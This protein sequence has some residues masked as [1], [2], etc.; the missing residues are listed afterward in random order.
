[1][2]TLTLIFALIFAS[3]LGCS[4]ASVAERQVLDSAQGSDPVRIDK[5]LVTPS[6]D[7]HREFIVAIQ[8][9]V[10]SVHLK[11]FR[12]T[13]PQVIQALISAKDRG[14]D[15]K[16]LLD[17]KSLKVARFNKTLNELERAG[18]LVRASSMGFSLTHEKSMVI[19]GQQAFVTGMNLTRN[20]KETRDFGIITRNQGITN[21]IE[22]VFAADWENALTGKAETPPLRDPN[23]IW[24][25]LNSR[26]KL[27]ALINS[28]RSQIRVQVENLGDPEIQRA[29]SEAA[30]RGCDVK[31]LVPMCDRDPKPLRNYP[32]VK[33]LL[34]E[35][36]RVQVMPFPAS[37]RRPYIHAK[38]ILIDK[39][40]IYLGSINFSKNS[41]MRARELGIVFEDPQNFQV[42]AQEFEKDWDQSVLPIEPPAG[43]CPVFD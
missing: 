41:T 39:T 13:D 35:G 14:I 22:T 28:A 5:L 34:S 18:V 26:T 30:K 7:G 6:P 20:F 38:M 37:E 43:F 42:L 32:F 2:N 15:V 29:F 4:S 31:I 24:S 3:L 19:D 8:T 1:M 16:I 17:Q 9:A 21:E 33:K 40:G 25:P 27:V 23:L 12:L 36:V 10:K 11:M